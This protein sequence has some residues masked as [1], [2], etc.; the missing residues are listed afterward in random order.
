MALKGMNVD[1][2]AQ[3]AQQINAGASE[4]EALTGRMT[5]VIQGFEWFGPDADRTREQWNSEYATMLRQV[6]AQLQEFSQ[7]ISREVQQQIAVSQ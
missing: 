2:G 1:T 3:A 6:Q 5:N 7:L 4:L